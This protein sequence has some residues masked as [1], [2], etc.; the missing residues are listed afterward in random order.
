MNKNTDEEN[1]VTHTFANFL[2]SNH[3]L[4]EFI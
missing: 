4:E 3:R 1:S 2:C